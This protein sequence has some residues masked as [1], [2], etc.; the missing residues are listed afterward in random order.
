MK[1]LTYTSYKEYCGLYTEIHG[2][3]AVNGCQ[4]G[5]A[6]KGMI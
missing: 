3:I 1:V 6:R 2:L 4:T 5:L